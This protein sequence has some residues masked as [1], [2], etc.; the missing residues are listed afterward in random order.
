M[1][2][3]RETPLDVVIATGR[4]VS[5]E[6]FVRSAFEYFDLDWRKHVVQNKVLLRPSDISYRAANPQLANTELGWTARHSVDDVVRNMCRAQ[7]EQPAR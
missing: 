5:L 3:Q 6:Y 4:T 1:L 7:S 2:L